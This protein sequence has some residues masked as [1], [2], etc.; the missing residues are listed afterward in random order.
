M[1]ENVHKLK[2][3]RSEHEMTVLIDEQE[4]EGVTGFD[5]SY[6]LDTGNGLESLSVNLAIDLMAYNLE[7]ES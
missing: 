7:V 2:I 6:A 1:T 4:I 5:I 3:R